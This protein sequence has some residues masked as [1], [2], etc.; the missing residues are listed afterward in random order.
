[1]KKIMPILL[2]I[3]LCIGLIACGVAPEKYEQAVQERDESVQVQQNLEES[4]SDLSAQTDKLTA[5]LQDLKTQNSNLTSQLAAAEQ[6]VRELT[7]QNSALQAQIAEKDTQIENLSA[8]KS[9]AVSS[10]ATSD[11]GDSTRG[12]GETTVYITNT[13]AKYHTGSCSY[14][15]KS[16]HAIS[17]DDAQA[18]GY[19]PC[20]RCSPPS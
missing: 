20:S 5:E 11:D 14:L 12:S 7:D 1:M 3:L 13:G 19:S 2:V 6:K 8:Q 17:L 15:K 16:K 9:A 4:I 10:R 18:Q